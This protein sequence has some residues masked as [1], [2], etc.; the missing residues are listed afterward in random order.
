MKNH[1]LSITRG[2]E[3]VKAANITEV[4]ESSLGVGDQ[5]F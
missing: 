3:V 2:E 5:S 1:T 4:E